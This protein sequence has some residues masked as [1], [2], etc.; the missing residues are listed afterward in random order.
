MSKLSKPTKSVV[1]LSAVLVD[2]GGIAP[3][4]IRVCPA[5]QFRSSR[6]NRP[7][8]CAFWQLNDRSAAAIVSAQATLSS[9]FLIDYDHASLQAGKTPGEVPAPAAGWADGFE[10]RDGDG[11]YAVGVEWNA[12]ALTA[13]IDKTYRYISPVLG[14]DKSTGEV[15]SV[16]MAALT[17][18]PAIDNLNDLAAAAAEIFLTTEDSSMDELLERLRYLLNL[19]ISATADD[20]VA[21]LD[22][23]K[24]QITGGDGSTVGLSALLSGLVSEKTALSSQLAAASTEVAALSAKVTSTGVDLSEYVPRAVFNEYEAKLAA[25]S[26]ESLQMQVDNLIADGRKT[27][28]IIGEADAQWCR[29][30]GLKDVVKLSGMLESRMGIAALSGLQSGGIKPGGHAPDAASETEKLVAKQL[31]L[32]VEQIRE[33]KG[34]I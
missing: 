3:T 33:Q 29:E 24:N 4:E 8:E 2:M 7:V 14:Y 20:I 12:A 6:D 13:I 9:K 32:T 31:G 34:K 1:A 28:K 30:I 11:L 17:N 18:Y 23:L 26:G 22:K 27:G 10:W 25:L 16:L 19:P 5:G 21:E 15:T